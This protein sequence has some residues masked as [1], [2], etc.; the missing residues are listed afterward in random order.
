MPHIVVLATGGTIASRAGSDGAS[1][2]SD[3]ADTLLGGTSTR[4]GITVEAVDLLR[5]NSFNLSF[6][7][8]RTI[9]DGVRDQLARGDVDG[10]VITHGTDTIEET[11]VLLDLIHNDDRPVV[12][13]GAQVAPDQS[14]TDGQR[15]LA[16]AISVA[17]DPQS[18]GLGVL[19][20]FAGQVLP[21]RGLRK[22]HTLQPQ[23]YAA[24]PTGPIG[25]LTQDEL[26][27]HARPVRNVPLPHPEPAFDG[28]RVE[29]LTLYPGATPELLNHLVE[30]RIG[31]I[32][33]AGTGAGNLNRDNVDAVRDA[34]AAGTVVALS[35]RVPFG[36]VAPIYG[37][38]G[39]VDAIKAGAVPVRL[40]NTQ[41]RILLALLLS[42]FP[43]DRVVE[44]LRSY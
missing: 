26:R 33:L 42:H 34:T 17:A 20:F 7:D 19:I 10:I 18:R 4:A 9:A 41:A 35:T 12:L 22:V 2:A 32:V 37:G 39:A 30:Q 3:S 31:G 43:A 29:L 1:V 38:G 23:P 11:A 44:R 5:Q 13:T 8:L 40:P 6:R 36:P 28:T 16:G 25:E 24:D 21:T 15:N 27:L 14:G